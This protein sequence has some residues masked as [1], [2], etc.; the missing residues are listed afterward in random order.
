MLKAFVV[1]FSDAQI[2]RQ[3]L[4]DFLDTR[5]E[6]KNW[7]AFLPSAIFVV[8]DKTA[9]QIAE[10]IRLGFPEKHLF[11]SEVSRGTNDGWLARNVWDFINAPNS[12]GRWPL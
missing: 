5:P 10:I 3:A 6:V 4:L 8:S 11:V 2:N 12:S 9:T 1:I 7:F